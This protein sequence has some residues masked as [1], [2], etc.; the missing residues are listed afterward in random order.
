M[1]PTP[2]PGSSAAPEGP[3]REQRH[4]TAAEGGSVEVVGRFRAA[5]GR[6]EAGADAGSELLPTRLTQA[7][8][9]VLPIDGAGLSLLDN[10]FRVPIGASDDVAALA[11]RLQFTLGEGP[12]LDAAMERRV[13]VA[14]RE[15]LTERWPLYSHELFT[16]TPFHGIAAIP[17]ALTPETN[18]ALDL[19]VTDS[20]QLGTVS[21][22]D[23]STLG[24]EIVDALLLAQA[25]SVP[26]DDDA[27]EDAEPAWLRS[28]GTRERTFVWIAMGMMMTEF[29]I[30]ATDALAL[31]R[32]YAYTENTDLD[33]VAAD[34]ASGNLGLD[35]LRP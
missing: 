13:V 30:V 2:D 22:A 17:L 23:V 35:A 10:D 15:Q 8:L 34:L 1:P 33:R 26:P 18:V 32:S 16:R 25:V 9:A 6:H 7:C 11:E 31:L 29:D 12:C 5:W 28:P 27:L 4:S 21:L 20:G 19:F 24:D 14:D 3:V